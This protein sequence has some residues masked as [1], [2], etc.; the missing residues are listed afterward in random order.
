M[1]LT[2][3]TLTA[4]SIRNHGRVLSSFASWLES[5]GYTDSNVLSG[6][7]LPKANEVRMEP[8]SDEEITRL[9]SCFSLNLEIG[10]RNA[11]IVCLFLDTGL[12]CA[13]LVSLEVENLFLET[14]RLKIL[15]KGRKERIVPFGHQTKRILERYIH[16]LRSEHITR[17]RVFL[18]SLG[19]PIT[20]NTIKMVI[21]RAAV[22]SK[23]P[24]L[25]V[26]LLRHTFA[27]R[28]VMRGGDTMW[29][30]TVMG[31]ERLETTQRYVKHGALQQV[32]LE[33][34]LCP[35]DEISLPRRIGV[36]SYNR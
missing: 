5:E 17:N 8:L 34:A 28:F 10:C 27:T 4:T 1:P 31:H 29:L 19:Y 36:I 11:A 6:I 2:Q 30:Q 25:H 9:M 24:R 26:H 33:R 14:K 16:H 21:Q 3:E 23:I 20:E 7:K 12:R 22:K 13:E 15:G 32:V 35:M 18:T